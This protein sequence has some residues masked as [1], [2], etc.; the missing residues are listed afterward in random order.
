MSTN[1]LKKT[2]DIQN[3]PNLLLVDDR[4]EN[5]LALESILDDLDCMLFKAISG[6]EA[7]RLVIKHDFALALI[8]VQMPDVNGFELAELLR[9]RQETRHLPIIFVTA[10]SQEQRYVFKGYEAGAVDYLFKPIEPEILRSK[11]NV[12][13][14][15][16]GQRQLLTKQTVELESKMQELH[17]EIL[18]RKRIEAEL[19][20]ALGTI[21][22]L[23]GSMAHEL[24]NILAIILGSL[25]LVIDDLT[26]RPSIQ[27]R[28]E[29]IHNTT[30][31][32]CGLVKEILTYSRSAQYKL[33]P[34]KLD[35][36]FQDII[37]M[38]QPTLPPAVTIH[39]HFDLQGQAVLVSPLHIEQILINL[40]KN[41]ADAIGDRKG[42][43]EISLEEIEYAA[44]P[45]QLP[46]LSKGTYVRFTVQDDG[47]G[48]APD[49]KENIFT[50]FF[51][52]KEVG[53]GTGLGLS[54]VH[55]IVQQYGG[56]ISVVSELG[57][58]T[59]LEILLP[60]VQESSEPA[61]P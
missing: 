38:I 32:G 41:A 26:D 56:E 50:P 45:P 58:G 36:I 53:K 16:Y 9:G 11:V 47:E 19:Q 2:T 27:A 39:Y 33:Y 48:I 12:F 5:L 46:D 61:S 54:V 51:T 17:V 8:D 30:I 23:A 35:Q 59:T 55:G 21:N 4:P 37:R 18:E 22:K 52:T 43:I 13:L 40:C 42:S 15:L 14:E 7:L 28:L 3:L 34:L 31:R 60:V 25:E 20:K 1:I 44:P 10:M 49:H 24:N 6:P 29:Q 57:Q